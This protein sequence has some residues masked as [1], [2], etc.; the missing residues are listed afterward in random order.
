MCVDEVMSVAKEETL[1]KRLLLKRCS[2]N[3]LFSG[4]DWLGTPRYLNTES[5]LETEE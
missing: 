5:N 2:F 4:D 1:D 3:F